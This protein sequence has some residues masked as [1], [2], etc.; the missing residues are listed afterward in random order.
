MAF[1]RVCRIDDVWQGDMAL[2]EVDGDEVLLVHLED[3]DV[4]AFD[5]R[6]PHQGWSLAEGTLEGTVLTCGMHGWEFDV[7]CGAGVNPTGC[8]LVRYAVERRGDEVW[9]DFERSSS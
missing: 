1:R 2:L 8:S 6:C 7:R 5:P 4:R 9:V 3:D